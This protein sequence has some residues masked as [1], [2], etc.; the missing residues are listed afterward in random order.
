M[1]VEVVERGNVPSKGPALLLGLVCLEHGTIPAAEEVDPTA[2]SARRPDEDV[3]SPVAVLIPGQCHVPAEVLA[4][5]FHAPPDFPAGL[6]G[7]RHHDA[8]SW[9]VGTTVGRC[10]DHVGQVVAREVWYRQ[11]PGPE[12]TV[13]PTA[14]PA[15]ERCARRARPHGGAA[16]LEYLSRTLESCPGG[17]IRTTVAVD[18]ERLAEAESELASE[19]GSGD[20]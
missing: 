11:H 13:H 14:V 9:A 12:E 3:G 16:V 5:G 7:A 20:A 19:I 1:A 15:A 4:L 17:N 10:D 2:A 18:V 6:G 8:P